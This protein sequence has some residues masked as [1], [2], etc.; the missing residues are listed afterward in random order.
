MKK[1]LSILLSALLCTSVIISNPEAIDLPEGEED[2]IPGIEIEYG[3]DESEGD[4]E[5]APCDDGRFPPGGEG[6]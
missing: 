4:N 3:E 1:L 6:I 5:A 2:N